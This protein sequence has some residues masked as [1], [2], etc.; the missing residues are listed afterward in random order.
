MSGA[1]DKANWRSLTDSFN[2]SAAGAKKGKP[3][4]RRPAP[5]SLRLTPEE[6]ARL[7]E[8]ANGQ[9]LGA[10]IK[11]RLFDDNLQSRKPRRRSPSKELQLLARVLRTIGRSGALSILG[12]L[13]VAANE[14]RV[15]LSRDED[16]RL[17]LANQ[18]LVSLRLE[19]I[20][21]LG[22]KA[23]RE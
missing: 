6:R 2:D 7:V 14:R 4:K 1:T 11:S 10:Y 3:G 13:I 15:V 21:A 19:L 20:N 16:S 23:R 12:T 18:E 22:V 9:P 8:D 5:L 17:R